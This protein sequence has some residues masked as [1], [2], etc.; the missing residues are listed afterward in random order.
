MVTAHSLRMSAIAGAMSRV[1]NINESPL[2][3][4]LDYIRELGEALTAIECVCDAGLLEDGEDAEYHIEGI[5]GT[6]F[7]AKWGDLSIAQIVERL[8]AVL[9][10]NRAEKLPDDACPNCRNGVHCQGTNSGCPCRSTCGR[11]Q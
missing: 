10:P 1:G 4:A 2:R 8:R 11:A 5:S 3:D 9:P 6:E 7:D